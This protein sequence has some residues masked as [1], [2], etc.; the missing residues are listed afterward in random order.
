[1]SPTI[2]SSVLKPLPFNRAGGP[3]FQRRRRSSRRTR[4]VHRRQREQEQDEWFKTRSHISSSDFHLLNR[5]FL[6]ENHRELQ[7]K[8]EL[9]VQ[10]ERQSELER[11][12]LERLLEEHP[13]LRQ[14][15]STS[16]TSPSL[17]STLDHS[18]SILL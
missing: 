6:R 7:E 8:P 13:R 14:W 18:S 5:I 10:Y 17:L 3:P 11:E 9:A 4:R 16:N 15:T 12:K 2:G 1:M